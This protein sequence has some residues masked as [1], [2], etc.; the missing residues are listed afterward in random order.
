MRAGPRRPGSWMRS[1]FVR[2]A[3]GP[4]PGNRWCDPATACAEPTSRPETI[5]RRQ[6]V[7][8]AD[9]SVH[10]RMGGAGGADHRSHG[11]P[12]RRTGLVAALGWPAVGGHAG[13]RPHR[14]PV[15]RAARGGPSP[16]ARGR[17]RA[18]GLHRQTVHDG[19]ADA[20]RARGRQGY[21]VPAPAKRSNSCF[22]C[23]AVSCASCTRMR[24]R[25][26]TESP[27]LSVRL[28]AM[29]RLCG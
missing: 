2:R 9:G 25:N 29:S 17:R 7:R 1:R 14:S 3:R 4:S 28:V 15:R 26:V 8:Y 12:R 18:A 21:R 20:G 13:R 16:A 24:C 10:R 5:V 23:S 6:R 19:G 11:L 27:G 22:S